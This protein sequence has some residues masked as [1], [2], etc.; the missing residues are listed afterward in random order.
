[1]NRR[2]VERHSRFGLL[3]RGAVSVPGMERGNF[4]TIPTMLSGPALLS[5]EEMYVHTIEHF[6]LESCAKYKL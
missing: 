6:L 2:L 4:V 3:G 1:M 5:C